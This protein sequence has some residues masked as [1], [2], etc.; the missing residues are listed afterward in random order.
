MAD[1]PQGKTLR[2]S[3]YMDDLGC[4][5]E[6]AF[7]EGDLVG[8]CVACWANLTDEER[9]AILVADT[10]ACRAE[11]RALKMREASDERFE[12]AANRLRDGYCEHSGDPVEHGDA[13]K[14][15]CGQDVSVVDGQIAMHK[16]AP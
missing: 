9:A 2:N 3:C 12:A 5:G 14:C 8:F 7:P 11:S 6:A 16:R 15:Q 4:R 1:A 10:V 13:M